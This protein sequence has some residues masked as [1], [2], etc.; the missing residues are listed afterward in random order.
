MSKAKPVT[1]PAAY[2]PWFEEQMT[3]QAAAQA[4]SPLAG[5]PD[6]IKDMHRC[7]GA[8][9]GKTC[10]G[11]AH[12]LTKRMGGTYFKCAQSRVTDG[13]GTDWRKRWPA[14]GLF[15]ERGEDE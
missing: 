2:L 12:L 10:G 11:C 3:K 6:R 4:L 7:H 8:T 1:V 13:P 5:L 9:E 14:C 15:V